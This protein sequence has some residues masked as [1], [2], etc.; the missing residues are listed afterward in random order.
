MKPHLPFNAPSRY[1]DLYEREGIH[2]PANRY[3]PENVPP[4]AQHQ[5]GELRK[6]WGIPQEG[7]VSDSL[8]RTLIHGYY[9]CVSYVD[10]MI[11]QVLDELKALELDQQ[12]IVI[13]WGDHGYNL[14]EHGLWNKH[15]N[16]RTSLR[17]VLMLKVPGKSEGVAC[18]AMVEFVDI[19][20]TLCELASLDLPDH[21]EGKSLVPL[22]SNPDM[23]WKDYVICK[24]F[25]G[26]T[27]KTKDYAYTEWSASDSAV[28]ARMLFD[29]REDRSENHNISE[30]EAF[31]A[32]MEELSR[33]MKQNRGK[34]FN[35]PVPGGKSRQHLMF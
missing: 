20:P 4:E 19:Y 31:E 2:L 12:T 28:Y 23:D 29:H 10:Q 9:A 1:W 34:D 18:E 15:C 24:W 6:Y 33:L 22:V 8:A 26:L 7:Q 17:S 14:M 27:I 35:K 11:G 5:F 16:Y 25:D 3:A 13:L 30:S 32:Q 21:L